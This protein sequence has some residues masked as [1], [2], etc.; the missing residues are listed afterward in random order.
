[1]RAL[2]L[3]A[4]GAAVSA[5]AQTYRFTI[6]PNRSGLQGEIS[7]RLLTD[8]FLIGNYDETTNPTGTRTKP[9]LF[10][11]FGATENLPVPSRPEFA[12]GGPV[13]LRT[14]GAVDIEFGALTATVSGYDADWLAN[15]P[16]ELPATI[17]IV[18]DAFRTRNPT[19]L[20]PPLDLPLELGSAQM[21]K[22]Q[23]TQTTP[24]SALVSGFGNIKWISVVLPVK[25]QMETEFQGQVFPTELDATY[26]LTASVALQ[27]STAV[28]LSNPTAQSQVFQSPI[29]QPL[30]PIPF[31]L[32]T[33][34]EPANVIFN[35][36][37]TEGIGTLQGT[38]RFG[39][40]GVR[41]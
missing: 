9:G 37:L 39:A 8:G 20:Y 1:M 24:A 13:L 17:R 29:N 28:I 38:S 41:L 7:F 15:G 5:P 19:F 21:T 16:L 23:V 18:T 22:F 30:P 32:P 14:S 25:I 10:G 40:T 33:L 36:T 11:S 4:L 26:T 12:L 34:A 3:V 27:G 2:V 6:D 31:P 35:L